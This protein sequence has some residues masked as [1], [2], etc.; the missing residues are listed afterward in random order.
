MAMRLAELDGA[1][2]VPPDPAGFEAKVIA[3]AADLV[4]AAK[5]KAYNRARR[6]SEGADDRGGSAACRAI[7][8]SLDLLTVSGWLLR[9]HPPAPTD[10]PVRRCL[11]PRGHGDSH[12]P[13]ST[14]TVTVACTR[15]AL[16]S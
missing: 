11:G 16:L 4:E 14:R 13:H 10:S 15:P 5:S 7:G 2:P 3:L 9:S 12:G 1:P 8:G 6:R